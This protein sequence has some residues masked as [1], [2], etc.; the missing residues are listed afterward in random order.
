MIKTR[1]LFLLAIPLVVG[2]C[3]YLAASGRVDGPWRP[4][5]PPRVEYPSTLD[6]GERELGDFVT[7][8]YSI[9]NRGESDLT[10]DHIQSNCAC[11]GIERELA[12]GRFSRI[13]SLRL[14]PGETAQVATR[15]VVHGVPMGGDMKNVLQFETNDPT[16]PVGQIRM[17]VRRVHRGIVACPDKVGLG[18]VRIGT[19][20]RRVLEL[21]DNS[22]DP[23]AVE[24]VTSSQPDR[25]TTKLLPADSTTRHSDAK[26]DGTLMLIG[27]VEV[28]VATDTPAVIDGH[29]EIYVAGRLHKPDLVAIYGR[30]AA[31]I[32]IFPTALLLPRSSSTGPLYTAK[33]MCRSTSGERLDVSL[34]GVP[35][36]LTVDVWDGNNAT[37]KTLCVTLHPERASAVTKGE[38]LQIRIRATAG[39]DEAVLELP[40]VLQK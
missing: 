30:V 6:L 36:P 35:A 22:I 2:V 34:E 12:T 37:S 15:I 26:S 27:R 25:I 33:C 9:T 31:A 18:T 24:R 20:V 16:H 13:A 17:L 1:T 14:Q 4:S 38:N 40:V 7:A 21:Y 3:A 11:T 32:E 28:D 23:R 39:Q 8:R 10:I 29:I 5:R 19:R